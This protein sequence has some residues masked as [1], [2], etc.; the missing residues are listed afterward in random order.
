MNTLCR[1]AAEKGGVHP[2]YL[3]RISSS[4]ALRL[5][6]MSSVQDAMPLMHDIFRSY[7]R[8]VRK[9]SMQSYSP[10]VQKAIMLVDS[11]LSANLTLSTLADSQS[12]SPGYLSAV[13][14]KETGRTV[15]EYIRERRMKHAAHLLVTTH[16]QVQ[17]VALHCGIMDVQYFSKLFK[18][19]TGKTPREY[20]ESMK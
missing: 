13:F 7:C 17:T 3:D 2:M 10:V 4:F 16:L 12:I 14:R 9:H 8:L 5:E 18:K 15:S 1:K 20:R 11:D 19:E 6:Q